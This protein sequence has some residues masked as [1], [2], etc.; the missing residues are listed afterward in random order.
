MK[1]FLLVL[2]FIAVG[3]FLSSCT[4]EDNPTEPGDG[5][6]NTEYPAEPAISEIFP[7]VAI[8]NGYIYLIGE[9]FG[10]TAGT[11]SVKFKSR[12]NQ[13]VITSDGLLSHRRCT[14]GV[15]EDCVSG[16][17]VLSRGAT[18]VDELHRFAVLQ[19]TLHDKITSDSIILE[20]F[21]HLSTEQLQVESAGVTRSISLTRTS[22]TRGQC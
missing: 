16:G 5:D 12:A 22:Q 1:Y 18:S 4:K 2:Y 10:Q 17:V 9:N 13:Q 11:V 6:N 8:P 15:T 14:V 7:S 3:I 19:R 20:A 21:E